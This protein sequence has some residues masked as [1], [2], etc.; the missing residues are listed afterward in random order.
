MFEKLV[1]KGGHKDFKINQ[2]AENAAY[3]PVT[4]PEFPRGIPV[5]ADRLAV[6]WIPI[7]HDPGSIVNK[8]FGRLIP[9]PPKEG[10]VIQKTLYGPLR[11]A[12]TEAWPDQHATADPDKI[13]GFWQKCQEYTRREI[14]PG[15][16]VLV[17]GWVEK[18]GSGSK[19]GIAASAAEKYKAEL[20]GSLHL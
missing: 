1:R 20:K 2:G 19:S 8:L 3:L 14:S 18:T 4:T 17:A 11:E 12:L 13:S 15:N 6:G 9:K 7:L 5:I 10:A 16:P